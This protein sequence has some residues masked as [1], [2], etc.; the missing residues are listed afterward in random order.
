[1]KIAVLLALTGLSSGLELRHN[2]SQMEEM[3]E[4]KRFAERNWEQLQRHVGNGPPLRNWSED[5][6]DRF[7]KLHGFE[8]DPEAVEKRNNRTKQERIFD[9]FAY[10][11]GAD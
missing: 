3:R 8:T 11:Y 1:M 4:K 5:I 6:L 7:G 2:R 10:D 9:W